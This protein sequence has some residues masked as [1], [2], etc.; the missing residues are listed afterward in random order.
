MNPAQPNISEQMA[1]PD[2]SGQEYHLLVL[3]FIVLFGLC[4]NTLSLVAIFH[5][6]LRK[7]AANQYLIVL[8]IADSF[9][10]F[11][12]I[13]MLFKVD[14]AG[15]VPCVL[16]EYV[17]MTAS[18]VSSWSIAALTLERYMAIANPLKH[19]Q[20][21]H[22]SRWKLMA[23]WLPLPFLLNLVQFVTLTP[24]P[25]NE[26]NERKCGI[27][28]GG[29]LQMITEFADVLLCYL[30]PCCVVVVL[31]SVIASKVRRSE[32]CFHIG[33]S[34]TPSAT[35]KSYCTLPTSASTGSTT[36]A[37]AVASAS[38]I[39][40]PR[41]QHYASPKAMTT[42]VG[43]GASPSADADER[44]AM[45]KLSTRT[46]PGNV[47]VGARTAGGSSSG[48][49]AGTTRIL[50]VVPVVYI[51][52]NTPFYMFRILDTVAL[53]VFNSTMFQYDGLNRNPVLAWCYNVAHY[54]YYVNFACDVIVYAFSSVN[55]RRTVVIV[56]RRIVCA[57]W[58]DA[59]D[60]QQ[61]LH[62]HRCNTSTL[63]Y[64]ASTKRLLPNVPCSGS[65]LNLHQAQ[66][67]AAGTIV[68]V[69][70]PAVV[71]SRPGSGQRISLEVEEGTSMVAKRMP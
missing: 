46:A 64:Q 68:V 49:P 63:A 12:I 58:S 6:R 30:F 17:L 21:G 57:R 36:A 44:P 34:P 31:N 27:S 52:L 14:Y 24:N 55:F 47:P 7:M 41:R 9:F 10:L 32:K 4:G 71:L 43:G 59:K 16:V 54:L 8:T 15:Y 37:A 13:L 48:N 70:P 51:L 38:A 65:N 66:H 40:P 20:Y 69:A 23:C 19:V 33:P 61:Q 56:W 67:A 18:Y 1:P 2:N 22:M 50:L 35:K 5:S 25:S 11:G 45:R 42:V 62:D 29:R 3:P 26:P 53:N 39:A 60:M 28:D